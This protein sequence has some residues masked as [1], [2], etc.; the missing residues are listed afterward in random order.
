MRLIFVTQLL[1]A[2]DAVLGFVSRWVE[3]LAKQ[4][5]SVRVL[6][7]EVGD[8]ASL[9]EN[10]ET[11][12]LGRRGRVRRWLRYRRLLTEAFAEGYD[13]LLTH[14]VPRYSLVAAGP[15][16]RAGVPHYLWYTHKGVDR[17]LVRAERVVDGIFTAGDESLRL[18]TPKKIITGHGIDPAHFRSEV[19]PLQPP[20]LLSVGRLTPAKDPL[21]LIEA[22]ALLRAEGREVSLEWAGGALAAGD[23]AFAAVVRER[24]GKLGLEEHVHLQG[25][26]PYRR[27]PALYAR[28]TLLLSGSRTGSVDKVVLEAMAAGR[29]PITCNES[30]PPIFAELGEVAA[31]LSFEPGDARGLARR[32]G[33]WLDRTPR[34]REALGRKLAAIV[35]RDHE[36][37]RLMQRLV[38]RMAC[39]SDLE[40][41]RGRV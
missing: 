17:R 25:P 22:L 36:V 21:T 7:L 2:E 20:L 4:C 9:P 5:E 29:I 6:A 8:T 12:V 1:D 27:I 15:A 30:F 41:G 37:D 19:E 28:S 13:A 3:G 31:D 32:A 38:E 11:R 23:D 34:E 18:E 26:V 35:E 40:N 10:V 33:C 39:G 24:I 16:R 14:M